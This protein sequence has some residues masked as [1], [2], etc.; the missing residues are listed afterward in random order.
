MKTAW[1]VFPFQTS[2]EK[3]KTVSKVWETK[4]ITDPFLNIFSSLGELLNSR[5]RLYH[6]IGWTKYMDEL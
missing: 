5:F 3:E 1:L 4:R 6:V 2:A